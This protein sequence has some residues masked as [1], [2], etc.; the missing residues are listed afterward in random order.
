MGKW[1]I[2]P[3]KKG[4]EVDKENQVVVLLQFTFCRLIL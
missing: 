1:Q 3:Q 4:G 2:H